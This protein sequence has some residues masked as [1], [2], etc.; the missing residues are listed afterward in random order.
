MDAVRRIPT[1][2]AASTEAVGER[3]PS[4][5]RRFAA[6]MK[7]RI[8]AARAVTLNQRN[9]FILPSAQGVVF[10]LLLV[11]LLIAAINYQNSLIFAFTFLLGSAFSAAIWQ[12]FLNLAGLR[13]EALGVRSTFAGRRLEYRFRLHADS[14]RAYTALRLGWPGAPWRTAHVPAGGS[15]DLVLLRDARRRG[16]D[17]PGR[18][19]IE[20]TFPL[21]L[22]RAWSWL[23][24]DVRGL[25][26]PRPLEGAEHPQ[27]DVA[28][29][30]A[31]VQRTHDGEDLWGLRDYEPGD[32]PRR[33]AWKHFAR[34]D[35]LL[36]R[37]FEKPVGQASTLDFEH[38]PGDPETRLSRLCAQVIELG[39]GQTDFSLR[40][41]GRTIGP[42]VGEA[43]V[44]ACLD[45]LAL[46]GLPDPRGG[47][48]R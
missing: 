46:Y 30:S 33:M 14:G 29:G 3:V 41:P 47:V 32:S 48:G 22:L 19:R 11:L 43:H 20:T 24:M 12:T 16:W 35:Q 25:V 28:T 17:L 2:P 13:I 15:T 5:G 39:R 31:G 21:G 40:L 34:R 38:T 37:D 8:P 45:A 10:A 26:W 9:V 27:A 44:N 6:F 42:D 4:L 36:T 18:L 1:T 23:D 7:R